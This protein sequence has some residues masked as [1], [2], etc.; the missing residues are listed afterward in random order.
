MGHPTGRAW[1]G[2]KQNGKCVV[3]FV[4]VVDFPPNVEILDVV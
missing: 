4:K 1:G 3:D 2:T